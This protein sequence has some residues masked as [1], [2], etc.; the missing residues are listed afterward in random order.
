LLYER[1]EPDSRQ[2]WAEKA[3]L[4]GIAALLLEEFP[5]FFRLNPLGN[6]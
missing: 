1:G 2:C 5:L 4:V 3:A 6:E